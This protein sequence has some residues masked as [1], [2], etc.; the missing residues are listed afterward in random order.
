MGFIPMPGMK[1]CRFSKLGHKK[2]PGPMSG[3]F[4]TNFKRRGRTRTCDSGTSDSNSYIPRSQ[5]AQ[6]KTFQVYT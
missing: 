4:P 2:V 3:N 1:P 5:V 6:S